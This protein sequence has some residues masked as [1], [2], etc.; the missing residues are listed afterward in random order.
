MRLWWVGLLMLCSAFV[1]AQPYVIQNFDVTMKLSAKAELVVTE[2]IQVVFNESRRGIFR[3]IPIHYEN[4]HGLTR[5]LF[6]DQISVTDENGAGQQIKI[7][8]EGEDV[9]IR[10]GD[11]DIFLPPGTQRT[12]M[13]YYRCRGMLN[14]FEKNEGW[15][16]TA[17]LYWNITGDRWDTRI[18]RASCKIEFPNVE[19]GK[20][21]RAR[22]FVGPYGSTL[23]QTIERL[24]GPFGNE[25]TRTRMTLA[26]DRFETERTV[27][28]DAYEGFTVVLD[29]PHD[30][31]AKPAPLEAALMTLSGMWGLAI[32]LV[33][34][35]FGIFA[36]LKWGKDPAP[37]V[38]VVQYDPPDDI[39]GPEAGTL[40]DDRVDRRDMSAAFFS[41]AVKGHLTI[42]PKEEGLIF[43]HRTAELRRTDK[44][45]TADLDAFEQK[46][47]RYLGSGGKV[48]DE[49]DL[50]ND[51]APHLTDLKST[52]YQML[53]TRGYYRHNPDSAR[54]VTFG[55]GLLLV[56]GLGIVFTAISPFGNPVPSIIGGVIGLIVVGIFSSMMPKRTVMGARAHDQVRGFE[57]FVRRAQGDEMDWMAEHHPDMALFEKYL[58]HAI[59]FGLAREW[60]KRFEGSLTE[61]PSWYVAPGYHHFNPVYFSDDVMSIS[62]SLGSAAATPPRSSGASGG[63]SGFSGGGFSGG[64]FG[65]G[66]GGSW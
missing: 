5:S 15:A 34:I 16:P 25:Q 55:L 32:P 53:V 39:S 56:V 30:S 51:V 24:G 41:L 27:P 44:A 57:E 58:P 22:V 62:D 63:G 7:T 54:G 42:H 13:I 1:G 43:K 61:M 45:G 36:W 49:T 11:P 38:M 28:L 31:I 66:G 29:L 21:L 40:L 4:R 17:Q 64:G 9:R 37:G 60:A 46:L 10:I 48:I 12:Y 52:L 2:K 3:D 50:R 18:E 35:P 14:W 59:A 33:V 47:L 23:N 6:I 8:K 19:G 65:G 20:D 26:S